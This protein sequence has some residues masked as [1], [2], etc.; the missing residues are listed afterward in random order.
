ME[1]GNV[2]GWLQAF[3]SNVDTPPCGS[4][5]LCAGWKHAMSAI[6][7]LDVPA[8]LRLRQHLSIIHHIPG[9]IRLRLGV[10]LWRSGAQL[11]RNQ[12]QRLLD[13]LAGIRQVRANPAVASITIEYDPRHISPDDW[14]TLIHGD[15]QDASVLLNDWLDSHAQLLRE[16]FMHKE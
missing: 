1:Y 15:T 8:L 3:V 4:L 2:I 16:T 6:P 9:R 10:A 14:E 5:T 13:Q 11:D 12:L 7:N